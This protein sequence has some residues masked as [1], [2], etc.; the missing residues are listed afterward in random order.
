MLNMTG[1]KWMNYMPAKFRMQFI[2]TMEA[3]NTLSEIDE[4]LSANY[5]SA[6]KFVANA[7]DWHLTP[8]GATYWVDVANQ[9]CIEAMAIV[10]D[11]YDDVFQ[12]YKNQK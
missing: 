3:H 2:K 1:Y 12:R 10:F 6:A 4:Y 5:R 8:E 9:T 11:Q 7:F